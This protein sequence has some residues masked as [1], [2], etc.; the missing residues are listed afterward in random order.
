MKNR[1]I[2]IIVFLGVISIVIIFMIQAYWLKISYNQYEREFDNNVHIA[3]QE[4]AEQIAEYNNTEIGNPYPVIQLSS[5]YFVVSLNDTIN[6]TVLEFYLIKEMEK[7]NI[8]ADFE[9]GTYDCFSGQMI[10]GN[11][12]TFE[13]NS[14]IVKS[15]YLSTYNDLVYYFGVN[16]PTKLS[17]VSRSITTWTFFS[18]ISVIV[19]VFFGY[20]IFTILQQQKFT[21]LQ[22]DFI[23][24]M[25]HEFRT[26]LSSIKLASDFFLSDK[27]IQSDK[28]LQKYSEIIKDQN[29][30]LNIQVEN[31][32]QIA[33]TE[34]N[35]FKVNQKSI[36]I[37]DLLKHCVNIYEANIDGKGQINFTCFNNDII[38]E[39]DEFHL[40]N[41]IHNIID[42]SI[43]YAIK[44]PVININIVKTGS[45]IALEASD[46]GIGI[47]D[48]HLKKVFKKFYRVPTG[49]VHDV[50]GFGLGLYY[51]KLICKKHRWNIKIESKIG[52]GTKVKIIMPFK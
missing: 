19:L 17:Y 34:K 39:A 50:K 51:V 14:K 22:K 31:V 30:R 40:N 52:I 48:K 49:D 46:N 7:V 38:I 42:N 21:E 36:N 28:R 26:P 37:C 5:S 35:T 32:L 6:H 1:E 13:E 10:Y 18:A 2:K 23:N 43:K 25:T 44:D 24:N 20:S 27:L 9:Y 41:I 3:L 16:F 45:R 11:Y 47:E 15:E 4:V 12:I 33:K 29:N 8:K